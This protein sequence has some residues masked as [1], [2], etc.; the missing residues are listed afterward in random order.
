MV[1]YSGVSHLFDHQFSTS[2]SIGKHI[3]DGVHI[4]SKASGS[5]LALMFRLAH[6][7]P[8]TPLKHREGTISTGVWQKTGREGFRVQGKAQSARATAS[9]VCVR[10]C[11][12][13]VRRGRQ[14]RTGMPPRR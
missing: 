8:S 11:L 4:F 9:P 13:R 5:L 14:V 2:G 10:T 12:R 7:D 6:D 1:S 3:D